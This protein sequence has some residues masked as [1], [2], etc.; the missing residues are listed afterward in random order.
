MRN[1][2]YKNFV[3]S[4]HSKLSK[5]TNGGKEFQTVIVR[6]IEPENNNFGSREFSTIPEACNYIDAFL[7]GMDY[8]RLN[9]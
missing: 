5:N 4:S 1:Q 8:Q 3:I 6:M 7:A 2:T 9:P